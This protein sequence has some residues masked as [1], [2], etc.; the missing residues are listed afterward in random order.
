MIP[1]T[2]VLIILL[3]SD[4]N[5]SLRSLLFTY[6]ISS[7]H[8]Y[9]KNTSFSTSH[10]MNNS[11]N[12]K[13]QL[14]NNKNNNVFYFNSSVLNK[15]CYKTF[16]RFSSSFTNISQT[17]KN[18]FFINKM[19]R[20]YE[21]NEGYSVNTIY[22]NKENLVNIY[23]IANCPSL[24][25]RVVYTLGNDNLNDSICEGFNEITINNNNTVKRIII[26]KPL[27]DNKRYLCYQSLLY[28]HKLKNIIIDSIHDFYNI[29]L[30][31]VYI[32]PHPNIINVILR[33]NGV[34]LSEIYIQVMNIFIVI[35]LVFVF[36]HMI[37]KS[38]VNTNYE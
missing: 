3:S 30:N 19:K 23:E 13:K 12:N 10:C 32:T 20:I 18:E 38:Y 8:I 26:I 5:N 25:Y 33:M 34:I 27:S 6:L 16:T 35:L 17:M 4:T 37:S 15:L 22:P 2:I 21:K 24:S 29:F 9:Q 31:N 28:L 36:R 11:L 1:L 14:K 7:E